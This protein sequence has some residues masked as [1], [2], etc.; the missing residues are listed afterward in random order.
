MINS[1]I[2]MIE[3]KIGINILSSVII[4]ITI[5]L[6]VICASTYDKLT[7][8]TARYSSFTKMNGGIY[9]FDY[10]EYEKFLANSEVLPDVFHG[11][12]ASILAV[13]NTSFGMRAYDE[14]QSEYKLPLSEGVW[15]TEADSSDYVNVVVTPNECFKVGDIV[16]PSDYMPDAD[17]DLYLKVCGVTVDEF[18][19]FEMNHYPEHGIQELYRNLEIKKQRSII[20]LI[21]F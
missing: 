20:Q 21:Y 19:Y 15:Y 17:D 1:S 3:R 10:G 11:V 8:K 16:H 7:E 18:S 6:G 14:L 4:G 9:Y 12:K 13:N 5:L 2:R